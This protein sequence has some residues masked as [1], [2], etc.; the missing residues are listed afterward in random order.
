MAASLSGASATGATIGAPLPRFAVLALVGFVAA[1]ARICVS[2]S[3]ASLVESG[4]LPAFL[5]PFFGGVAAAIGTT[6]EM[7]ASS[8]SFTRGEAGGAT[9]TAGAFAVSGVPAAATTFFAVLGFAGAFFGLAAAPFLSFCGGS[10][11]M[12]MCGVTPPD[13]IVTCANSLFSSSYSK[14]FRRARRASDTYV[15]SHG[16]SEMASSDTRA[17]VVARRISRELEHF[18]RQILENRGEVH[19]RTA[20]HTPRVF[21]VC[22][23]TTQEMMAAARARAQETKPLRRKRLTR[24]TGN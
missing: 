23:K 15:L 8:S 1:G 22:V 17:L 13:A 20:A 9:C 18:R 2:A 10:S 3:V 12:W 11:A 6:A 7:A 21:V 5:A 16:E 4:A 14:K 19:A 24:P